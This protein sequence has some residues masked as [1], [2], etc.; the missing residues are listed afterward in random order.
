MQVSVEDVSTLTK[1]LKI[2]IPEDVV[3]K[4]IENAFKK[5]KSDVSLK[6]FRK[7]KVP[8]KV[9]EKSYG[10]RVKM[11]VGEK[12]VQDTYFDAL[13]Q[14]KCEPVVH[15]D[16][17]SHT[18]ADDGTFIYEAE[19]DVKPV[20]ELGEYKGIEVELPEIVVTD[21]AIDTE[22]E[23]MRKEIAPL[24]NVD[25]RAVE[26]ND[27]VVVDFQ[28]Y[29]GGEPIKQVKGENYSVEI[30]SGR[31]GIEFEQACIGL[32]KGD[33]GS[34]EVAFPADF[35]NPV[36]A[37]K[38]VEFKIKV[39]EIKER[40]LP[41]IDDDFAK[42]VGE[43]FEDLAALREHLS[44][45]IE[46]QKTEARIGDLT[47]QVMM[48]ILEKHDFEVPKKLIAQ[49]V[50]E[51]IKQLE[52]QLQKQGLTLESAGLSQEKLIND[53]QDG[54]EK[55][56]RGDFILK[57]IAEVEEIKISD[58]DLRQA[59]ERISQQY[60]M[61]VD[62]VKKFFQSRNDLLPFMNELLSEKIVEFLR[63]NAVVKEVAADSNK[64]EASKSGDTE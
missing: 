49:E 12:L 13:E 40:V 15:P 43:E 16:I 41:E 2:V 23:S 3:S 58:D 29:D 11:E 1:T 55:R 54:A 31:N 48:K 53:Y 25:D 34:K 42:D 37:G 47:D 21:D 8:R 59:F 20:F 64:E 6:G 56:I 35:P 51:Q 63:E 57:K 10:E 27:L 24:R 28:G 60:G 38:N 62:E 50:A 18:F 32:K 36:M 22:I 7:G 9:L 61:P 19:I 14:T 45:K 30:G 33:E 52:E 5:L 44:K 46:K 26:L 17:K 4:K 39:K